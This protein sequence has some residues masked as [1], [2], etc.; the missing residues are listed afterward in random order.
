MDIASIL[1][2]LADNK[3]IV[4]GAFATLSEVIVIIVNCYRKTKAEKVAVKTLIS[5]PETAPKSTLTRKL[6]WSANP[7]NLFREA[8]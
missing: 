8:V 6:L 1:T 7:I 3:T 5:V 2:W 4:V